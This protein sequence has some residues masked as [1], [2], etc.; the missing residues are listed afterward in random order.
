MV[1]LP[2]S[3]R[4]CAVSLLEQDGKLPTDLSR[5]T[6]PACPRRID[7][8]SNQRYWLL[9]QT[10]CVCV[11]ARAC[12]RARVC[13]CAAVSPLCC[14][15]INETTEQT[16]NVNSCIQLSEESHCIDLR[17]HAHTQTHSGMSC[18]ALVAM[19]SQRGRFS[20]LER[21]LFEALS[22]SLMMGHTWVIQN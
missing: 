22:V 4:L 19:I 18:M 13:V 12:M 6:L 17:T 16:C 20:G 1:R 7:C 15:L 5:P 10:V 14:L 2:P 21:F 3:S 8:K 11:C 9:L